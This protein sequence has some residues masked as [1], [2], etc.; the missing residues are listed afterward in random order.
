MNVAFR[1]PHVSVSTHIQ[2]TCF[3]S[4]LGKMAF[5]FFFLSS[6]LVVFLVVVGFWGFFVYDIFFLLLF[7][8]I[9]FPCSFFAREAQQIIQMLMLYAPRVI[10]SF[11]WL[12]GENFLLKICLSCFPFWDE[13]IM[14]I[15][16]NK[17]ETH[18]KRKKKKNERFVFL[19]F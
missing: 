19:S 1:M 9:N 16:R 11:P 5:K 12:R 18:A 7:L 10:E 14:H 6:F 17:I 15:I 3:I 2:S 8:Y 4:Y 13:M